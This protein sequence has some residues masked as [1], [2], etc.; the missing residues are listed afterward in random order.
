MEITTNSER[1][2]AYRKQTVEHALFRAQPHLCGVCVS[3]GSCE[4]QAQ[5][6]D[7]GLTHV[8][9]AVHQ[10]QPA[11]GCQPR[12]LIGLDHNRCILCTRCVR[13]CDEVE[14]AHTW[15]VMGRGAEAR[16][17]ADLNQPWGDS[18]ELHQLRQMCAGLPHR[19]ACLKKARLW[20][21]CAKNMNS[22]PTCA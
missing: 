10:P 19:R 12:L 9:G 21:K 17:V 15:D 22:C 4:L 1:L 13:V 5:A 8:A 18:L 20:P 11:S 16:I 2:K 14:G 7:L 3:N 6:Y